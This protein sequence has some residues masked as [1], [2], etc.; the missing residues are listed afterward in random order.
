MLEVSVVIPAYNAAA[1]IGSCL[2]A[3]RAQRLHSAEFEV[4]V[5]DDGSTDD[6]RASAEALGARTLRV[7]R[8]GP[9]AARN[10]GIEAARGA[11]IACTDADCIPSSV[12]L[13]RLVAAARRAPGCVGVAGKTIG[14]RSETPAA[15]FVDLTGGLDSENYLGHPTY[16][17]A[18][19]CNVMFRRDD[20]RKIGGFDAR[21]WHEGCD[22]AL[23]L[24]REFGGTLVHE[25]SA[26]TLHRH[27]DSWGG[28]Y[29][30]QRGYGRFHAQFMLKWRPEMRWTIRDEVRAWCRLTGLAWR[31]PSGGPDERLL[32]RGRLVRGLA[33]RLGFMSAYW[34]P[35]ER[36]RWGPASGAAAPAQWQSVAAMESAP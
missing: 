16:P 28:Y 22:I 23:R 15:R 20:L 11:W 10:A 33:Q 17:F 30:Q 31:T 3:L 6:T 26:L 7:P 2:A 34:N 35:R 4:I 25:P 24:R 21:V 13:V 18:P 29:R 9:P 32:R 8:G 27:R 19:T 1:M 36:A 5:V 14:Y 12:W